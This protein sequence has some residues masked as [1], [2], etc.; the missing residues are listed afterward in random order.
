M[1]GSRSMHQH[2][3]WGLAIYASDD[4]AAR[5]L[6]LGGVMYLAASLA[7]FA[8][9]LPAHDSGLFRHPDLLLLVATIS[10]VIGTA[11]I[12]LSRR[13][14]L[15]GRGFALWIWS[16]QLP[17]VALISVGIASAGPDWG[18]GAL[19]YVEVPIIAVFVLRPLYATLVVAMV[20]VGFGV[21]LFVQDGWPRPTLTLVGFALGIGSVSF[22]FGQM[23]RR[24]VQEAERLAQFRRFLPEP[25]ARVVATSGDDGLFESHRGLVTVVFCDLR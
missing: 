11:T 1:F 22:A 10:V 25:V 9:V 13:P 7:G 16:S 20:L 21:V 6:L 14:S 2:P 12:L 17:T 5:M 23:L 24:G 3:R 4:L 18:S 15:A 19:L 8:I